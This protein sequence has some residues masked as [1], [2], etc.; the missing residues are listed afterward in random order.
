MGRH[1]RSTPMG[2]PDEGRRVTVFVR[3]HVQGVGF[4]WWTRARALEL[5]LAGHARNT[6]DRRVEVVAE[7]PEHDAPGA[8]STCC[9]KRR[10]PLG[11]RGAVTPGRPRCGVPRAAKRAFASGEAAP[12]PGD[13]ASGGWTGERRGC[14]GFL[15]WPR[16]RHPARPR[17]PAVEHRQHRRGAGAPARRALQ[18]H[19][20]GRRAQGGHRDA[21]RRPGPRGAP[22]H[23]G[24]AAW[25]T[26]RAWTRSSPRSSSPSSS[27][28]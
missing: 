21:A 15:R 10:R 25:P 27:P 17:T 7:G 1:L 3:G 23:A 12:G 6:A 8:C 24:C 20:A 2:G 18:G 13:P 9:P 19:A 22:D 11:G 5:G 26:R 14:R 28:R 16:E 4:R